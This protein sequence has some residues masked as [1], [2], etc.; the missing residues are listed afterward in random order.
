MDLRLYLVLDDKD[1][2]ADSSSSLCAELTKWINEVIAEFEGGK[3]DGGYRIPTGYTYQLSAIKE[4]AP[5]LEIEKQPALVFYD[6][7]KNLALATLKGVQYNSYL[8]KKGLR[9][10]MTLGD[11]DEGTQGYVMPDGDSFFP[12]Y[13]MF[14]PSTGPGFNPFAG[15]LLSNL[16]EWLADQVPWWIWLIPTA[17]AADKTI[18]AG[19]NGA[20]ILFGSTALALKASPLATPNEIGKLTDTYN[21]KYGGRVDEFWIAPMIKTGY[22]GRN[23]PNKKTMDIYTVPEKAI[24]NFDLHA[25]EFGNWMNQEDRANFMFATLASLADMAKVFNVAQSRMGLNRH[26]SLAFGAR[27]KGGFAAAF[28]QTLPIGVI[29]LTKTK[30]MGTF[31]HEYGHAIDNYLGIK[32]KS[33]NRFAS[34]GHS[35]RKTVDYRGL[36]MN[37]A[38]YFMEKIMEAVLY[39]NGKKSS[40]HKWLDE[41]TDYYNR[42]AE[43]FA[44]VFESY[45]HFKL[46][47]KGIVNK[48]AG[49]YP[50]PDLPKEH[51]IMAAKPWMDKLV[52]M[53]FAQ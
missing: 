1:C 34:G 28:Y 22:L 39:E 49:Y 50:A 47:N 32:T 31:A 9:F 35:M 42:R 6:A 53:A 19:S 30:G 4:L 5:Q 21:I 43:I 25:I 23:E 24:E 52:K 12:L 45:V 17:Y 48:W 27:G 51:L 16:A 3:H 20:K 40:Y 18:K 46:K 36:K 2:S 29:N 10:F 13:A 38:E 41:E 33:E 14:T 15:D 37:S 7:D 44:R 8:I 11:Y 26:L